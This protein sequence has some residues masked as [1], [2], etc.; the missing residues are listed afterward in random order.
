MTH[1]DHTTD[2][3]LQKKIEEAQ[4]QDEKLKT[5]T[6]ETELETVKQELE[7]MTEMAKRTMADMQ[8]L[9]RRQEEERKTFLIM[10]NASLI[11]DF[12][13]VIDNLDRAQ[14]HLSDQGLEMCIKQAKSIL[15]NNGVKVIESVGQPFNPDHHEAIAEGPGEKG[16]VLDEFE[17]GYMLGD[18]IIRHAKVKVGNGES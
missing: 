15:Q 3:D 6:L 5:G 9:R 4:K 17:K 13:P 2:D 1:D 12:L 10:S 11:R 8:N 18:R 16:Q 7:Q 14:E